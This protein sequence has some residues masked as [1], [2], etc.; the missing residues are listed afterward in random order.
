MLENETGKEDRGSWERDGDAPLRS[1]Q[2]GG[3]RV[4]T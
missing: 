2:E 3:V 4:K 1:H